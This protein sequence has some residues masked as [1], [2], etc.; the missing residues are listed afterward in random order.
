MDVCAHETPWAC[1]NELVNFAA[2]QKIETRKHKQVKEQNRL[3]LNS[4]PARAA[5]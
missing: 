1:V 3:K 5:V 4:F 2:F